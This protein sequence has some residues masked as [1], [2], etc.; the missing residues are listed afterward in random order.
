MGSP[1]TSRRI[2]TYLP[3]PTSRDDLVDF[4]R[5]LREVERFLL[6]NQSQAALK[7][8]DG[9]ETPIPADIFRALEQVANAL[10]NGKG[11]TVA[12]YEMR[13]TTQEAADFL[14]MSRPTLVKLLDAGVI[15]HEKQGRHRRV[16]LRDLVSYQDQSRVRRR[17]A[18]EE[19]TRGNQ[20]K[21]KSTQDLRRLSELSD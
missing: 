7:S 1:T 9:K 21:T 11:V 15:P 13:L 20:D 5:T 3:D 17:S 18:L 16:T 19:M 12:P 2:E 8:P 10:A 4:A 6:A 14:S